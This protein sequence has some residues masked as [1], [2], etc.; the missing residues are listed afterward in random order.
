MRFADIVKI[1]EGKQPYATP[2]PAVLAP[3]EKKSAPLRS[4]PS[5]PPPVDREQLEQEIRTQLEQEFQERLARLEDEAR[6]AREEQAKEA[7]TQRE[8]SQ[9]QEEQAKLRQIAEEMQRKS[10]QFEQDRQQWEQEIKNRLQMESK[11]LEEELRREKDASAQ[12]IRDLEAKLRQKQAPVAPQTPASLADANRSVLEVTAKAAAKPVQPPPIAPFQPA[13]TE[14]EGTMHGPVTADV[15]PQMEARVRKIYA[16]LAGMTQNLFDALSKRQAPDLASFRPHFLELISIVEKRDTEIQTIALEPY[17]DLNHF[18]YHAVNCVFFALVL[19]SELR[20]KPDELERLAVG[21]LLHD[22]G[23]AEIH[24]SLDY[25]GELTSEIKKSVLEH[26]ERAAHLLEG[27]LDEQ[28][29]RVILEHHESCN[30]KGYP[31]GLDEKAICIEAKILHA[32]D[33]FEAMT[34]ERPYRRKALD[35]SRAVKEIIEK[36]RGIYD[37]D[38]MK[39]LMSRIGLYP[40]MSL[41]ELSNRQIARVL[42]QNRQFPMSPVVQLEY[43]EEGNKLKDAPILD[44]TRN[45]FIHVV[46]PVG[47]VESFARR[48]HHHEHQHRVAGKDK[49]VIFK[50]ILIFAAVAAIL[51]LLGYL[52]FKI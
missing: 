47:S 38:V 6:R 23:L 31:K 16:D 51:G 19:G 45:H 1:K 32:V 34:H 20:L 3:S 40:V 29:K 17:P 25:P 27:F 39:A 13:L 4:A 49:A 14:R 15:D 21:A 12:M 37:R 52:V 46:G 28:T 11:R 24:E 36:G 22:L 10:V 35:V 2:R 7:V 48:H 41:V 50:Q 33:A 9:L 30:G 18:V 42:R 26:S 5:A 43:D 8:Q 44:L